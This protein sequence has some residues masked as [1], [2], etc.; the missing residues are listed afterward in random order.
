MTGLLRARD[1]QKCVIRNFSHIFGLRQPRPDLGAV[2]ANA[3]PSYTICQSLLFRFQHFERESGRIGDER[4]RGGAEIATVRLEI[5]VSGTLS[6]VASRRPA[7]GFGE[8][9]VCHFQIVPPDKCG[10]VA[11]P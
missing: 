6:K 8:A 1:E 7:F 5:R 4:D 2:P 11:R 3:V 10:V 9:W